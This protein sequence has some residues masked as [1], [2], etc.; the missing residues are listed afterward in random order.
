[1]KSHKIW[2][3]GDAANKNWEILEN[4]PPKVAEMS[5]KVVHFGL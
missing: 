1:L 5:E 3:V 4:L 2:K